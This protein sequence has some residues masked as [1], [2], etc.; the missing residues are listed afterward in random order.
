LT[1]QRWQ[2]VRTEQTPSIQKTFAYISRQKLG[3][4][5]LLVFQHWHPEA[6][7][8]VPKGSVEKDETPQAAALREAYEEA[9][10]ERLELVAHLATDWVHFPFDQGNQEVQERHFFHFQT[11]EPLAESWTH[12]V[13]GEGADR[14]MVFRYFWLPICDASRLVANMGDY[15]HLLK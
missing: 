7:I 6:G 12:Q 4:L 11:L 8:Q 1:Q 15:A 2:A 9:G 3:K 5:E 10:L 13:Q 14:G